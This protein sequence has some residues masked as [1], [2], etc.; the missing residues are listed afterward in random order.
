MQLWQILT[1]PLELGFMRVALLAAFLSGLNCSMVGVFVVLRRMAFLGGAL[2]HTILP[3][4]VAAYLVGIPIFWG[5]LAAGI[6]TA[7]GTGWI[8][9]RKNIR[10][11]TA[12]GIVMTAFFALGL[13]LMSTQP[14]FRDFNSLLFGNVLA[15]TPADLV[16]IG[17]VS[18]IVLAGILL[19]FKELK[20]AT[21]DPE[22][23]EL[24][25]V[26][27]NLLKYFLLVLTALSVVSAV[28]VVGALLAA[29]LLITPAATALLLAR[30]LRWIL[31][32][33]FAIS[34]VSTLSGLYFSYYFSVSSG[35]A[36]ALSTTACFL[37]AR[38]TCLFRPL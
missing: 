18:I 26:R 23:G 10:E 33:A 8:T 30:K 12:V 3:G 32:I 35:A 27:P 34:C 14:N 19:C 21:L 31:P 2:S 22:Y 5:A 15:V 36:I 38:L 37:L 7:L 1:D 25:G 13:L 16:L 17:G 20:L 4:I 11:D 29:A 9:D 28:Q 24:I 6:L